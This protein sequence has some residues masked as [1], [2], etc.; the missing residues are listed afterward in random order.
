MNTKHIE[1]LVGIIKSKMESNG[2][3]LNEKVAESL[4][5]SGLQGI[6]K[7]IYEAGIEEELKLGAEVTSNLMKAIFGM[8]GSELD[9]L[10]EKA[11]KTRC[12]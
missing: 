5:K 11:N 2:F 7:N 8:E 3:C 1:E 4:K 12:S 10:E 9:E 6:H